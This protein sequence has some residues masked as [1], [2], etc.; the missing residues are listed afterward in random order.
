MTHTFQKLYPGIDYAMSNLRPLFIPLAFAPCA[1][2]A[3]IPILTDYN[4]QV[5][6]SNPLMHICTP[7]SSPSYTLPKPTHSTT[8]P[9]AFHYVETI[10]PGSCEVGK[11]VSDSARPW[12]MKMGTSKI[13][14]FT[15]PNEAV[16][17]SLQS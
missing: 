1:L 10:T 7:K 14:G 15:F 11:A 16:R 17:V 9:A 13:E 2:L 6:D 3:A 8:K 12:S 4:G 5:A